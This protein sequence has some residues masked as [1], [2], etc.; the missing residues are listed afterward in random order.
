[1]VNVR[2]ACTRIRTGDLVE[3]DSTAG[4]IRILKQG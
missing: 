3:L 2:E 4:V 1:M